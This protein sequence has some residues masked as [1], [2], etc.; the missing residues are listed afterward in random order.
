MPPLPAFLLLILALASGFVSYR[1]FRRYGDARACE[2]GLTP[3]SARTGPTDDGGSTEFDR[4][5]WKE[6]LSGEHETVSVDA[7]RIGVLAC[8]W[9]LASVA[10]TVLAIAVWVSLQ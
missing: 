2:L 6:L 9:T 7:Q 8:R 4:R 1:C 10:L 5:V 3:E